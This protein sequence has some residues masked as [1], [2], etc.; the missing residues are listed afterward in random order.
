MAGNAKAMPGAEEFLRAVDALSVDIFY[1]TNR[2]ERFR[3]AAIRNLKAL[4]FPQV[5]NAHVVMKTDTSSK[6]PRFN[7]IS[8]SYNVIV[9]LGDSAHDF[10]IGIYGKNMKDRNT[11]TDKNKELF[12][13]KYI[14]LPNPIYGSWRGAYTDGY[15]NMSL[16][17]RHK[18]DMKAL[19]HMP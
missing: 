18:A 15:R 10:P 14:V 9:Y 6:D 16:E 5:D 3:E 17:D 12:G 4:N 2:Q 11:I 13:M 8:E 7:T 1:V 19:N